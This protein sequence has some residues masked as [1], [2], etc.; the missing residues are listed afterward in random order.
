V[1]LTEPTVAGRIRQ[2]WDA[3]Q[4]A[5]TRLP[6]RISQT[7]LAPQFDTYP[8][9]VALR[10]TGAVEVAPNGSR[11]AGKPAHCPTSECGWIDGSGRSATGRPGSASVKPGS[12]RSNTSPG[13]CQG[14]GC[15]PP[16]VST[17]HERCVSQTHLPSAR[18]T[19]PHRGDR[20]VSNAAAPGSPL[21]GL[22][23][24]RC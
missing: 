10:L 7:W 9:G 18:R 1:Y 3:A 16:K 22:A 14:S 20:A 6:E 8:L 13:S 5:A 24:P 15:G 19:P 21:C 12:T 11:D 2:Q 17:A 4:Y 23:V